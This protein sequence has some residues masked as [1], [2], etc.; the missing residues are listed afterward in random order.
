MIVFS[1]LYE[2]TALFYSGRPTLE[3]HNWDDVKHF[4]GDAPTRIIMAKQDLVSAPAG[5]S[6]TVEKEADGLI[7]GRISRRDGS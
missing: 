3:A 4:A 1:G 7:Y 5:Y 6:I 2:P